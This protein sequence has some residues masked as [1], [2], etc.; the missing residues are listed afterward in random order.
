MIKQAL[1]VALV[2]SILQMFNR[3]GPTSMCRRWRRP[4]RRGQRGAR[5]RRPVPGAT[6]DL[7]RLRRTGRDPGVGTSHQAPDRIP[8]PR[9]RVLHR[10]SSPSP[11]PL[12]YWPMKPSDPA[13]SLRGHREPPCAI[14]GS[15]P[16]PYPV[17]LRLV[18]SSPSPREGGEQGEEGVATVEVWTRLPR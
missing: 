4:R 18:L 16:C 10:P 15:G 7:D 1:T 11:N 2:K 6:L 14:H 12:A 8:N 17:A 9:A 3:V 13:I 5:I